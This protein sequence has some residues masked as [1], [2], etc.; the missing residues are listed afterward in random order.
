[1][2][3]NWL[4]HIKDVNRL[5]ADEL[6]GLPQEEK[7]DRLCALNVIDQVKN[8]CC[9]TIVQDAWKKGVELSV[10]GWIYSINNGILKSLD[11]SI[12]STGQLART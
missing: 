10:H 3:D 8:V 5:N 4:C 7:F 12:S 11:T 2:I 9:T 1:L 6:K